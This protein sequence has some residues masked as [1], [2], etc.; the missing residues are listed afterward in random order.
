LNTALFL[1]LSLM[2]VGSAIMVVIRKSPVDSALFLLL[3][4]VS[5]A[6]HYIMLD[7]PFLAAAQLI[8]YG[9]AVIVVFMFVIML[10][11]LRKQHL[12]GK[13]TP[14]GRIIYALFGVA[15][16]LCLTGLFRQGAQLG[17]ATSEK[18]SGT[19]EQFGLDLF[20]RWVYPFELTSI[21]LLAAMVGAVALTRKT[22]RLETEENEEGQ[23]A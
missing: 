14:R 4:M 19:I 20:Q 17:P 18:V 11:N 8:V 15:L 13:A 6:G 3:L 22:P 9:G 12:A 7:A 16:M 5:L 23:D 21:L 10:L 2:S 1:L